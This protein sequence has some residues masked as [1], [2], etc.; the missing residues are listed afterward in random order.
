[1]GH[2]PFPA[3]VF[4]PFRDREEPQRPTIEVEIVTWQRLKS[5]LIEQSNNIGM[6]QGPEP[7]LQRSAQLGTWWRCCRTS[8]GFD[9]N[10]EIRR[11]GSLEA[12]V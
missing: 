12:R 9:A 1:M 10:E 7:S 11:I 8:C 5:T 2:P 3:A 4:R 6:I